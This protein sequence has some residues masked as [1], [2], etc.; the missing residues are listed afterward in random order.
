MKVWYNSVP[1]KS[2]E[3]SSEQI[4]FNTTV[5]NAEQGECGT[6]YSAQF[7]RAVQS[8]GS[9]ATGDTMSVCPAAVSPRTATIL[10]VPQLVFLN[11]AQRSS[12]QAAV[13]V[14]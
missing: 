4:V 9:V 3:S 13:S 1:Q 8:K 2:A 5:S 14:E 7:V 11:N 12:L 10:T 6:V